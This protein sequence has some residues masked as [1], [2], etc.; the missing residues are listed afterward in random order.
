MLRSTFQNFVQ[1]GYFES[2]TSFS[3]E[4]LLGSSLEPTSTL[5]SSNNRTM[6]ICSCC[7]L[8]PQNSSVVLGH[9]IFYSSLPQKKWHNPMDV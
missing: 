7:F 4:L 6:E 3:V 5:P 9:P 8:H 1:N 2:N